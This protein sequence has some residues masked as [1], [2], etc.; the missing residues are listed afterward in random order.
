MWVGM[1]MMMAVGAAAE[2]QTQFSHTLYLVP[3]EPVV[4]TRSLFWNQFVTVFERNSADVFIDQ[5][6]PINPRNW[7]PDLGGDFGIYGDRRARAARYAL[8]Q[9]WR[10]ALR[11]AALSL[12]VM[13][14]L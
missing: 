3:I 10:D 5:F 13:A 14:W 11:E 2:I 1:V 7:R 6:H 12:P 4:Q 8:S 9:S